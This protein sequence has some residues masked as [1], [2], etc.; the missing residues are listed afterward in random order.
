MTPE[1]HRQCPPMAMSFSQHGVEAGG[2]VMEL[3]VDLAVQLGPRHS[4][5]ALAGHLAAWNLGVAVDPTPGH[6]P[7]SCWAAVQLS[8]P[9]GPGPVQGA[10]DQGA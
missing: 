9:P 7:L 6:L 4:D 5:R 8:A 2:V 3:A 1:R 10:G